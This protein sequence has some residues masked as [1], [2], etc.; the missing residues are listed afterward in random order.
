[1]YIN[2]YIYIYIYICMCIYISI[3]IY[4]Y[5]Y[6]CIYI[7]VSGESES[8]PTLYID[9]HTDLHTSTSFRALLLNVVQSLTRVNTTGNDS[10]V[11]YEFSHDS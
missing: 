7:Y 8:L 11:S 4:I 2:I 5:I 1:M 9:T 6:I 3:Y 10:P